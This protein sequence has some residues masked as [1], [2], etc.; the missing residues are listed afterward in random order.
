MRTP[1]S[2]PEP[3][4]PDPETQRGWEAWRAMMQL[5]DI[6]TKHPVTFETLFDAR[7]TKNA[8]P[9]ARRKTYRFLSG[10]LQS[11]EKQGVK[12]TPELITLGRW[13][14]ETEDQLLSGLFDDPEGQ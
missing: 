12:N 6:A 9:S 7:W 2:S 8:R 3:S 14:N 5:S 13:G 1:I 10:K 4:H 11:L